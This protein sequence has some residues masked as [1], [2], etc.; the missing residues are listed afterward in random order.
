MD[1]S[2]NPLT[3]ELGEEDLEAISLAGDNPDSAYVLSAFL[4]DSGE[5]VL[6]DSGG[7][8]S[9]FEFVGE[10][11]GDW[12]VSFTEV[13][14]GNGEYSPASG[15]GYEWVGPGA[16]SYMPWN[17]LPLP[18]SHGMIDLRAEY[19]PADGV[20]FTAEGAASGV[21]AN[22][23]SDIGDGD[24]A[25]EALSFSGE[26]ERPI[27]P[28]NMDLGDIKLTGTYRRKAER[29]A[30]LGRQES[31]EFARD[32]GLEGSSG[33]EELVSAG[34]EYSPT[35]YLAIS[36][37]YGHNRIGDESSRRL[38]SSLSLSRDKLAGSANYSRVDAGKR[39]DRIWG[40]L[41]GTWKM[42]RPSISARYEDKM[43]SSGFSFVE[44]GAEVAISPLPEL[45]IIPGLEYRRD[46]ERDSS[47]LYPVSESRAYKLGGSA[48]DWDFNY[49]HKEYDA[50]AESESDVVT[51]LA[52][53]EGSAS[54]DIPRTRFRAKYRLSREQSELLTP[55]YVYVGE[56]A[57]NYELD[58]D[59]GEF[60]PAAGGDYLKEYRGTG[61]FTPV[62]GSELR[63]RLNISLKPLSGQ[64]KFYDALRS[65]SLDGLLQV[66][67]ESE[68]LDAGAILIDPATMITEEDLLSGR[69]LAEGNLNFRRGKWSLTLGRR[70]DKSMNTRLTTGE[71]IRWE[72]SYTAEARFRAGNIG[73]VRARVE[74]EE[75]SRIYP[76]SSRTGSMISGLES[77]LGWNSAGEKL[78]LSA[79]I[80]YLSQKDRLPDIPVSIG[81]YSA[82]PG[83]TWFI[84]RGSVRF[85]L[86]YSRVDASGENI[87]I[88]PYEMAH[89]DWVG[90]NGAVFLDA[91]YEI[92]SGGRAG[93]S[94]ELKSHTGRLPEHTARAN[95][96]LTF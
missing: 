49:Y 23:L 27:S 12:E 13:G 20:K 96:R 44:S 3:A 18:A 90:D 89:G 15:G 93:L 30:E 80:G 63:S 75:D 36:S 35:T 48:G 73:M 33:G 84:P 47:G 85:N 24:N 55:E 25:G 16:G 77:T 43:G 50:L 40:D 92:F 62:V 60:I 21:D 5:Y 2:D 82:S 26:M 22:R 19:E 7:D 67:G 79:E 66:R 32:W 87:S 53:L 58:E 68:I 88:L 9:H 78:Q 38:Q 31:A 41:S 81:R 28:G 14:A 74:S 10:G 64:G 29:F 71:E 57:G 54:M 4:S 65:L 59:R 86:E 51:D 17:M 95:L 94:Y 76:E 52:S 46:S 61:E 70:Y 45:T 83:L 72:S 56:G 69:F 34:L 39:W 37:S 91:G 1:D 6:A 11:Y 42:L 8:S